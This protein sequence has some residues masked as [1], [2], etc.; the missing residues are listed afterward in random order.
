MAAK[1][2]YAHEFIS[3]LPDGYKTIV[4]EGLLSAGE[5]Q[6]IAIAR[7]ILRD[8]QILILDEATSALDSKSEQYIKRLLHA[9]TND[10]KTKRTVVVIAHRLSTIKAVDKIV[11]MDKGRIIE[12][13]N[14]AE[15]LEKDGLYAQLV[16]IQGKESTSLMD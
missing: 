11:V 7:A 8:P 5:K 2:A 10:N 9:L 12:V 15:L 13:G 3:S 6:R 14:H 16:K 4:D 1:Q